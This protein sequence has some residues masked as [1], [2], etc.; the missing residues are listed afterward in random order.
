MNSDDRLWFIEHQK[1]K[2]NKVKEFIVGW[3]F[4]IMIVGTILVLLVWV[5]KWEPTVDK[6]Q[7]KLDSLKREMAKLQIY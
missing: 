4:N 6:E 3:F 2:M 7:A 5:S 1:D